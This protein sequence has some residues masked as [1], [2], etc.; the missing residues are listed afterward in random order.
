MSGVRKIFTNLIK[1][2]NLKVFARHGV[3][4]SEKNGQMF[5][6]S[7]T[8]GLDFYKAV[9]FDSVDFTIDYDYFCKFVSDNFAKF[10]FN[11]IET[12]AKFLTEQILLKFRRINFVTVVINKE[13]AVF[14]NSCVVQCV[15]IKYTNFWHIAYL[16]LGSNLG[17]RLKNVVSA[18]GLLKLEDRIKILKI[19]KIFKNKA[20]GRKMSDFF[21]CVVK[22]KTLFTPFELLGFCNKIEYK[23]KR[24]RLE[25]WGPRTIDVD[26]LFFDDIILRTKNLVIPHPEIEKRDFVLNPMAELAPFFKHPV[27]GKTMQKLADTLNKE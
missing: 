12:A 14:K 11:L 19:S 21:N 26:I 9:K 10:R 20:Y 18:I 4:A 13:K 25:K 1:I 2:Q 5:I 24:V 27:N 23:L 3:Y 22:I 15:E 6:L 16:G 17:L 8:L 7:L